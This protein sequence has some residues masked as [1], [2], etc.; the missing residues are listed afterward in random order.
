MHDQDSA[1]YEHVN[2]GARDST[3]SCVN[4]DNEFSAKLGN[5][6]RLPNLE[7]LTKK[8]KIFRGLLRYVV[9]R[10]SKFGF[11]H[12]GGGCDMYRYCDFFNAFRFFAKCA[13]QTR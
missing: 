13:A 12:I 6:Y 9:H 3:W 10:N 7:L 11:D 2:H 5:S 8:L 4:V 1:L